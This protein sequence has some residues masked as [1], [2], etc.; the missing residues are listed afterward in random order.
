MGFGKAKELILTGRRI[1]ADEVLQVGLVEKIVSQENL[2]SE[3]EQMAKEILVNGSLAVA[4]AKKILNDGWNLYIEK[5]LE[6]ESRVWGSLFGTKD[7]K[8]GA[9]AFLEK[10]LQNLRM[11][12]A[13][14][15]ENF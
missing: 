1:K 3:T 15:D 7:Q 8:E 2:L 9:K 5:G 11:S 13:A 10:D 4:A 6:E 14:I 12:E